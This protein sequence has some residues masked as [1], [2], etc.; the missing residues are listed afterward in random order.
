MCLAVYI[1]CDN[2][3]PLI[4]WDAKQPRFNVVPLDHNEKVVTCQFRYSF[5]YSM[6]DRMRAVV[7]DLSRKEK[8]ESNLRWFNPITNNLPAIYRN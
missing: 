3:L 4:K 2:T 8:L 5:T 1:A 6:Q 7:V